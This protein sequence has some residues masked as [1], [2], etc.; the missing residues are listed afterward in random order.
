MQISSDLIKAFKEAKLNTFTPFG[1]VRKSGIIILKFAEP[2]YTEVID[3]NPAVLELDNVTLTFIKSLSVF[4]AYAIVYDNK[5]VTYDEKFVTIVR[6]SSQN[7]VNHKGVRFR[8]HDQNIN[9]YESQDGASIVALNNLME[10][11]TSEMVR[12]KKS[13]ET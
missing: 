1:V 10:I 11:I 5:V 7:L 9:V 3:S 2:A 4:F 12:R 13:R 8:H 6:P